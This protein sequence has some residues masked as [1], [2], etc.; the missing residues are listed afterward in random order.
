MHATALTHLQLLRRRPITP[1]ACSPDASPDA[2]VIE[3]CWSLARPPVVE[4][5]GGD[6]RGRPAAGNIHHAHRHT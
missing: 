2:E 3:I 5:F 6:I 1:I 4:F